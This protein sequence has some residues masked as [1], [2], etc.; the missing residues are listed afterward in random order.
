MALYKSA[1]FDTSANFLWVW[2]RNNFISFPIS[3]AGPTCDIICDWASWSANPSI[4]FLTHQLPPVF[5]AGVGRPQHAAMCNINHTHASSQGL[6][7][8]EVIL[9]YAAMCISASHD[10][11]L[12][13]LWLTTLGLWNYSARRRG[14]SL[15]AWQSYVPRQVVTL[16]TMRQR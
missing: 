6:L 11:S 5:M 12:E 4:R 15:F 1:R 2:W 8:V 13:I 7:H 14:L 3:D 9:Q 16:I 10:K